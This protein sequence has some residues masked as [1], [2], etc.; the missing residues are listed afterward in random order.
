MAMVGSAATGLVAALALNLIYRRIQSEWP[1]NYFS[2]TDYWSFV[3]ALV[4]TCAELCSAW[5][6]PRG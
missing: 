5:S 4:G 1:E 6:E 3:K 2:L